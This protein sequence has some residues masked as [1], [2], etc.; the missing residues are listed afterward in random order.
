MATRLVGTTFAALVYLTLQ[1]GA[2][3]LALRLWTGTF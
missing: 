1:I 2:L 3:F